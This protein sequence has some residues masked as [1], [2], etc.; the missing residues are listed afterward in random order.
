YNYCDAVLRYPI[1]NNNI[2]FVEMILNENINLKNKIEGLH[3][4][5]ENGNLN[6]FKLILD[7]TPNLG[8][9]AVEKLAYDCVYRGY[10]DILR[11][12]LLLNT[13]STDEFK[14]SLTQAAEYNHNQIIVLLLDSI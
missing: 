7:H 12:I 2:K 11:F 6:I 3:F 13:H 9:G 14:C 8:H 5:I 10:I 1:E 4:S